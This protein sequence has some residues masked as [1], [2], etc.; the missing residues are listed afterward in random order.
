MKYRIL[1]ALV[2]AMAA[3]AGSARAD[4]VFNGI[5]YGTGSIVSM[6]TTVRICS[7]SGN[8][9]VAVED[10]DLFDQTCVWASETYSLGAVYDGLTCSRGGAGRGGVWKRINP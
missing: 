10:K 2:A 5:S 4:C 9:V 1:L 7:E 8:W 3:G 6:H